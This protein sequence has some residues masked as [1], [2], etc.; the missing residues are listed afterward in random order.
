MKHIFHYIFSRFQ[1]VHMMPMVLLRFRSNLQK[2][3]YLK[4]N[5][6]YTKIKSAFLS[7]E[8]Y[9]WPN[10]CKKTN[11]MKVFKLIWDEH[12]RKCSELQIIVGGGSIIEDYNLLKFIHGLLGNR[13]LTF[14]WFSWLVWLAES[15]GCPLY[16]LAF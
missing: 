2:I 1:F 15:I 10:E 8:F 16:V 3:Y 9:V 6:S 14:G 7:F 11:I 13:L 5:W 12:K 4:K